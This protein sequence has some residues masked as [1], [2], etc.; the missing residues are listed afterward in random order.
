ML[1]KL[2][3]ANIVSS[4]CLFLLVGGGTAFAASQLGKNTVGSNQLKKNSVTAAKI[5]ANA[6][7][8]TK[9][10][11]GAITGAKVAAGSLTGANINLGSLGTVPSANTANTATTATTAK[12]ATTAD[13]AKSATTADT[14]KSADTAGNLVG[15]IPIATFMSEGTRVLA[16]VGPF[17]L[18][19]ECKINNGGTDEARFFVETSE[20]GSAMDDNNG[21]EIDEWN[22]GEPAGLYE[23]STGTGTPNIE[24]AEEPGLT[25]IAPSGAAIL[26]QN[27]TIGFNI[28]NRP[29]QCYL[30]GLIQKIG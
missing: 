25:A 15:R 17:T 2:T 26:F 28:A 7:T 8:G 9:I 16:S 21:D 18:S 5:K 12:S 20:N 3:Y 29:G 4:V 30:A 22:A 14:A 11:N 1:S 19:A 27:E 24:A 13:T 6:V 10:K 23:E